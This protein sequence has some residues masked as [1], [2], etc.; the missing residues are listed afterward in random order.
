[1]ELRKCTIKDKRGTSFRKYFLFLY[2]SLDNVSLDD[3]NASFKNNRESFE[4]LINNYKK[5]K[6]VFLFLCP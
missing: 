6:R 3:F 1:M 2:S 5:V 4:E